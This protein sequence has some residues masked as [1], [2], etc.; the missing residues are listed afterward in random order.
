[1]L[2]A[3]LLFTLS[4]RIT[5]YVRRADVKSS[6]PSDNHMRNIF[7]QGIISIYGGFFGGGIG[8]MM[9]AVLGLMGLDNIHEMNALKTLLATLINGIAVVT[10]TIARAVAWPQALLMAV[11]AI[12]G[13]YLGAAVARRLN[14]KL[15]RTFVIVVGFSLSIYL[16]LQ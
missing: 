14:P 10:F 6:T 5:A 8:I 2:G 3:T 4:P 13:G 7:L 1:M 12:L 16:F 15:V 11:G 9:L